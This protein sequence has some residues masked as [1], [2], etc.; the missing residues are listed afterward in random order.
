MFSV[1]SIGVKVPTGVQSW[2][3]YFENVDEYI[4]EYSEFNKIFE[5]V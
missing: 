5:S 3:E 4:F 1:P 2:N